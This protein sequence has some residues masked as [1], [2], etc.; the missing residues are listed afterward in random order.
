LFLKKE[1]TDD[2]NS[3]QPKE[4]L[5]DILHIGSG[6][7]LLQAESFIAG[8]D[9]DPIDNCILYKLILNKV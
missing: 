2:I 9:A 5:I 3:T 6:L 4:E 8:F 7:R 1:A